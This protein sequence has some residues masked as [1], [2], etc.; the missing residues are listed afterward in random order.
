[1]DECEV[2]LQQLARLKEKLIRH[3]RAEDAAVK[4]IKDL[5]MH[6]F[7]LKTEIEVSDTSTVCN[8]LYLSSY[9]VCYNFIYIYSFYLFFVCITYV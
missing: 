4:R 7:A 5:E 8:L 6:I 3:S 9:S 2:P 1:M